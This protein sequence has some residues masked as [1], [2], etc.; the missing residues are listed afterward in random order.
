[1]GTMSFALRLYQRDGE[2]QREEVIDL[3][4]DRI[5]LGRGQMSGPGFVALL[6]CGR[7][8]SAVHATLIRDREETWWIID[9]SPDGGEGGKPRPSSRG[10][11]VGEQRIRRARIELGSR[12]EFI[13]ENG[14]H[15]WIEAVPL[16]DT[17]DLG[18]TVPPSED[19]MTKAIAALKTDLRKIA[20]EV[21]QNRGN[22]QQLNE[23]IEFLKASEGR[24]EAAIARPQD[25]FDEALRAQQAQLR[26]ELHQ[27]N[28]NLSAF[29]QRA[30]GD[31]LRYE[32]RL[33]MLTRIVCV[34]ALCAGVV[35]AVSWVNDPAAKDHYLEVIL[36]L[37]VSV[38]GG[39]G[40]VAAQRLGDGVR[41]SVQP[42]REDWYQPPPPPPPRDRR[43][44]EGERETR[45]QSDRHLDADDDF[46]METQA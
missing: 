29:Q 15:I 9:G 7:R 27:A 46:D 6:S 21:T 31:L 14:W 28:L 5:S 43:R 24:V 36:S 40:L 42:R 38:V 39:G 20:R 45:L 2:N 12:F 44:H 22:D 10:I 35:L 23:Q 25:L 19:E 1:M 16:E 37:L 3:R 34:M 11:W 17:L 13:R 4:E 41:P 26:R 18:A 32:A 33:R 30:R 8:V